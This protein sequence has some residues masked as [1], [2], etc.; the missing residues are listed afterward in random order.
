MGTPRTKRQNFDVTPEQD[1]EIGAL[2]EV[3]GVS[4]A[5]DAV[6]RAVRITALIARE[7]RQGKDLVL[8]SRSGASERLLIPELESPN[9]NTWMWLICREHPWRRQ[10]SVKGRRLLASTVWADMVANGQTVA[11]AAGEWDLPV[12]AVEE[13]VRWCEANSALIQM[14]AE[15]ERRQIQQT[16][17]RVAPAAR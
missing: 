2:R 14:E 7:T 17:V 8:R 10:M 16:G 12:E 6:L 3:L 1:A 11:E 5:K 4:T 15:E 13:V 9:A